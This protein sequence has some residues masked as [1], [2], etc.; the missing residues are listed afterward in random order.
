[1]RDHPRR[2]RLLEAH[3]R[4]IFDRLGRVSTIVELRL[5]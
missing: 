3:S 1:M 5:G 4:E 2:V